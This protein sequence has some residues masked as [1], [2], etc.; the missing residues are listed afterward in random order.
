M[1]NIKVVNSIE[2]IDNIKVIDNISEIDFSFCG[3]IYFYI[4]IYTNICIDI[5]NCFS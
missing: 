2:V 1:D 4:D 3:I 5:I